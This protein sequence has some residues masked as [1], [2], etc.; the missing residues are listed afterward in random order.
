MDTGTTIT[1]FDVVNTASAGPGSLAAAIA[2]ADLDPNPGTADVVFHIPTSTAPDIDVPVPGFDPG[3]ET[4]EIDLSSPLPAITRPTSIDGYTEANLGLYYNYP[5]Q[6]SS[7]VQTLS[8][9]GE[10]TG[11]SFTLTTSA[12][13]P[14]AITTAIPYDA[15]VFEVQD[16]LE[17]IVGAGNVAVS[18]GP[19]PDT[20]LT[21]TFQ[22]AYAD[23]AIPNLYVNSS[24]TG[25]TSPAVDVVTT[26]FGGVELGTPTS[27]A[28]ATN[29]TAALDGDNAELRVVLNGSQLT[30][31][32][33]LVVNAS[34]SDIRG[35]AIEGFNVGISIPSDSDVG[36]LIQGNMIGDYLAYPVDPAT[37]VPLPAPDT[38][39][40]HRAG[41]YTGDGAGGGQRDHW[42]HR[43]ARCQRD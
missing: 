31:A 10:P 6:V 29:T 17:A 19:L 28:S 14:A 20:P 36:D 42:R 4:W 37:G 22:G 5:S 23:L 12:P 9:S 11:G 24:L 43:P 33:G 15:G 30:G 34:N 26:T 3:T 16:A 27:F 13:L 41:E 21:I 35:L 38:V 7:A 39:R 8:I 40:A 32:T 2:A 1:R 25:G 18:G